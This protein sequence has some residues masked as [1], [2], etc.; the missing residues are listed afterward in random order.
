MHASSHLVPDSLVV[1]TGPL[2]AS[3]DRRDRWHR[4]S[5][6]LL[7]THPGQLIVP[8]LV[9]AETAYLLAE[10]LGSR[11]ALQFLGEIARGNLVTEPVAV[12]DWPR[13]LDLAI[14]YRDFPLG[15]TDA[16]VIAC[17]ERLGITTVATTDRRHFAAVRPRHTE[18]FD[19]LP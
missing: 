5:L 19:L 10:R 18:A 11:S 13:I 4:E 7:A 1:D 14:R 16:S 8:Q 6:E 12:V 15:T 2:V 9:V 17:A 3:A